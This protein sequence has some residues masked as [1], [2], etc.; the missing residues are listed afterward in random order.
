MIAVIWFYYKLSGE[1]SNEKWIC[2]I[3]KEFGLGKQ[4]LTCIYEY[5]KEKFSPLLIDMKESP[6]VDF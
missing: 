3:L 5:A 1:R 6:V 4:K 2:M